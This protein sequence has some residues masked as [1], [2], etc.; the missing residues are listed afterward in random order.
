VTVAIVRLVTV[1]TLGMWTAP[2][3]AGAQQTGNVYRIGFL[4]GGRPT[5]P[6][7]PVFEQALRDRGWMTGENLVIAYRYAEEKYGQL[8]ALAA[9][10]V[11]LGP[12]VIVAVPT[13]SAQAAKNVTSTIPIVMWGVADPVGA[14]LIT[15]F[16]RP[17][18]NVTG[19]TGTLPFETYAKQLQLL[20]EA[21]PRARRIAFLRNP[22]NPA[23]LPGAKIVTEAARSLGVEL[24]VVGARAPEE[25]EPAFRAMTQ[26]RT[27]ALLVHGDQ[28]FFPH[29]ARLADLSVRHRL[30]TMSGDPG[31]AKAGGFMNYSV[32]WADS[33][34]QVASYVDRL[35]RGAKPADLPVQQPTKF[36][37]I[38]NLKTAKALGVTLPPSLLLQADHVVD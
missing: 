11:R 16:A 8:P 26:A 18:G 13:A 27:D 9:E 10:L 19:F 36:E 4:T 25:F 32:D 35:L 6:V 31:Y 12:Q 1:L 7:Q 37:L 5:G 21:V 23:S 24:Q 34:R 22:N 29:L 3:V 2:L 38:I 14:G 30:P 28:A 15:S 17:G 20:K 33:V